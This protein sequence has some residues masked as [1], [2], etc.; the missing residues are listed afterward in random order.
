M[1]DELLNEIV[2]QYFNGKSIKDILEELK[3][4]LSE[5][6]LQELR[7]IILEGEWNK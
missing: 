7:L 6:D 5:E 4:K 1:V 3:S 2:K